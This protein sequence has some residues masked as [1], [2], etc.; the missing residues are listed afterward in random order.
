MKMS[1][2]GYIWTVSSAGWCVMAYLS[3]LA[4]AWIAAGGCGALALACL[5]ISNME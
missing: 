5:W 3:E 4:E 1:H 2:Q